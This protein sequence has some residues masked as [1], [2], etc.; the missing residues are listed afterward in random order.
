VVFLLALPLNIWLSSSAAIASAQLCITDAEREH[1]A[2]GVRAT[3][4]A[5]ADSTS[6]RTPDSQSLSNVTKRKSEGEDLLSLA[7]H[8]GAMEESSGSVDGSSSS[9]SGQR[10]GPSSIDTTAVSG[11]ALSASEAS[12]AAAGAQSSGLS[13]NGS[14][15]GG[16]Q[17]AGSAM[18]TIKQAL[19][20]VRG[21]L[22]AVRESAMRVW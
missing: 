19:I 20:D 10:V 21:T 7:A 11:G 5:A 3:E 18:A 14:G 1:I 22:P 15:N 2:A 8:Q 16:S 4:S 13:A 9:A 6:G 17:G 12:S